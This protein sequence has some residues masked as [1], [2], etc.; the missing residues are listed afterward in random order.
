MAVLLVG[1]RGKPAEIG[2][3]IEQEPEI[4][5]GALVR[6]LQ[7]T[8]GSALAENE[9]RSTRVDL[10]AGKLLWVRYVVSK[11]EILVSDDRNIS[12]IIRKNR[13][14]FVGYPISSGQPTKIEN[15]F[16]V[17][18]ARKFSG[19]IGGLEIAV[20]AGHYGMIPALPR[21]ARSVEVELVEEDGTAVGS[22]SGAITVSVPVTYLVWA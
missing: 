16:R 2:G 17:R 22:A 1:E 7:K 11:A 18:F 4:E 9:P 3:K 8:W 10:E 5:A 21:A 20:P 12:H 13:V 14:A 19:K 6:L 15:G